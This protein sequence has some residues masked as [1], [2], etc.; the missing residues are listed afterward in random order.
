MVQSPAS[1][2]YFDLGLT[3]MSPNV[4][5]IFCFDKHLVECSFPNF[6]FSFTLNGILNNK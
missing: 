6:V 1:Q 3:N 2:F 4:L 5:F